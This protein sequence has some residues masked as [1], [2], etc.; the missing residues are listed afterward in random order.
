VVLHCALVAVALGAVNKE[1][2]INFHSIEIW[3][4]HQRVMEKQWMNK[5]QI[6]DPK[7]LF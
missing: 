5:T 1:C 7:Q 6:Q 2:D 4:A 3:S